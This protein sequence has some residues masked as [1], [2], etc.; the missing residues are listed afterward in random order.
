MAT[1]AQAP[2][3]GKPS[4]PQLLP[5]A[6]VSTDPI[7]E[8]LREGSRGWVDKM[9]A[10]AGALG[11]GLGILV[12]IG[13]HTGY[14]LALRGWLPESLPVRYN[15]GLCLMFCGLALLLLV[16]SRFTLAHVAAAVSFLLGLLTTC[17]YVFVFNSGID[18]LFF[19]STRV[20]PSVPAR[21]A[22]N[23]AVCFLI[24]GGS[25]LLARKKPGRAR[26]ALQAFAAALAAS[27]SLAGL[28]GY[29]LDVP[30]AYSWGNL[31]P[32]A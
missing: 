6:A 9:V 15:A 11:F 31:T 26:N 13:W 3:R 29:V 25:L 18:Q 22:P 12:L 5:T 2:H 21:M 24:L 7:L 4:G 19:D 10:S 30:T 23:A 1:P 17:E 16:R 20:A 32:I 14:V 8:P 28:I 27:V